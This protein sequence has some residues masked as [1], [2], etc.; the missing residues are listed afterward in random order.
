MER[1]ESTMTHE[2]GIEDQESTSGSQDE[3]DSTNKVTRQELAQICKSKVKIIEKM[4]RGYNGKTIQGDERYNSKN[5]IEFIEKVV[6][7]ILAK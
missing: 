3:K 2:R 5:N 7:I 1:Q 4:K 6:I